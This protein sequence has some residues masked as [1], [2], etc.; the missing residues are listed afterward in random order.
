[1]MYVYYNPVSRDI[2]R[3]TPTIVSSK[4]P[5]FISVDYSLLEKIVTGQR[6]LTMFKV[7]DAD[8]G[9]LCLIEKKDIFNNFK[10]A[11][12]KD[13]KFDA[14]EYS[15][16]SFYPWDEYLNPF[17]KVNSLN[18]VPNAN[19]KMT[20][21]KSKGKISA[22]KTVSPWLKGQGYYKMKLFVANK[23]NYNILYDTIIIRVGELAKSESVEFDFNHN[24]ED[25][26]I[27]SNTNFRS[28]IYAVENT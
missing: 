11:Q 8:D 14:T 7:G 23:D 18:D 12:P 19:L 17:R 16:S 6:K 22:S 13:A 10:R 2:L 21:G 1:M 28:Q 25:I 26:I 24:I 4:H 15:L 9:S 20:L 27:F 3:V 5:Y